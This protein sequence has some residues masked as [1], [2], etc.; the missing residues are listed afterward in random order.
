MPLFRIRQGLRAG[1]EVRLTA[2]RIL[3]GRSADNNLIVP[4]DSIDLTHASVEV[5]GNSWIL[6]DLGAPDGTWLNDNLVDQPRRLL[7]GDVL[8]LG[9]VRIEIQEVNDDSA[10][11]NILRS[12]SL[13][14]PM[15]EADEEK[16]QRRISPLIWLILLILL[17]SIIYLDRAHL[18]NLGKVAD[19]GPPQIQLID[20]PSE[21][22]A[23]RG[24][25]IFFIS[26]ASD[27]LDLAGVEFWVNDILVD[28]H[29]PEQANMVQMQTAHRWSTTQPGSYLLKVIAF[30]KTGQASPP[31]EIRLIVE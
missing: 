14:D 9:K 23:R 25:T 7:N 26:E 22:R 28:V 16:P 12:E 5:R 11:P 30:D 27:S 8:K 2:S 3:I 18:L 24:E 13:L 31:V 20:T 1:E 6:Q 29:Q 21:L 17:G 15:P 4:D 19:N 10:Q